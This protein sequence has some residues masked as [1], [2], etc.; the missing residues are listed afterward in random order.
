M[1]ETGKFYQAGYIKRTA[2]DQSETEEPCY[3][4]IED[5]TVVPEGTVVEEGEFIVASEEVR[6]DPKAKEITGKTTFY[7]KADREKKEHL[8]RLFRRLGEFIWRDMQ[9]FRK[10]HPEEFEKIMKEY[11]Q[12]KTKE[13]EQ[14]NGSTVES[15][16]KPDQ[17]ELPS[18]YDELLP[19]AVNIV[20]DLGRCSVAEIRRRLKI[21]YSRC[22]GIVDQMEELGIV[23]P[24][25]GT[26][27]RRV[28]F[29][30]E[31]WRIASSRERLQTLIN[32]LAGGEGPAHSGQVEKTGKSPICGTGHEPLGELVQ[33]AE[34]DPESVFGNV[35]VHTDP[36]F[37]RIA[38]TRPGK[39]TP[40][41]QK[42]FE[43]MLNRIPE[44][45]RKEGDF[46]PT[47]DEC[48]Q[49]KCNLCIR[50]SNKIC[51]NFCLPGFYKN[52][53]PTPEQ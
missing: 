28:L 18:G 21:P 10:E 45:Y 14:E 15:A 9:E 16:Q 27:I 33:E 53:P 8:N 32:A 51:G 35:T 24:Y 26:P 42:L 41:E 2:P 22:A 19:Q 43:T 25:E 3:L 39:R 38:T 30:A 6:F 4:K 49:F 44:Q 7:V 5:D 13:T 17:P 34:E 40:E 23:G 50:L 1:I 52:I 29:S 48:F 46:I 37:F 20:L 11:E 36:E 31:D 47:C 12:S